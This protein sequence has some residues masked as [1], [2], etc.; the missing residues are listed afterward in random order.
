MLRTEIELNPLLLQRS[1]FTEYD[2]G[3]LIEN[4]LTAE[5]AKSFMTIF[6]LDVALLDNPETD[7]FDG[8]FVICL[9]E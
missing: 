8:S 6:G 7:G 5:K 4:P 1:G 3:N 9:C 2:G